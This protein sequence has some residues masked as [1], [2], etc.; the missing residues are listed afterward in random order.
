MTESEEANSSQAEIHLDWGPICRLKETI[1]PE[2]WQSPKGYVS[3]KTGALLVGHGVF[4]ELSI[5][6]VQLGCA[7]VS[8]ADLWNFQSCDL[9]NEG[10]FSFTCFDDGHR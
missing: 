8:I 3:A 7:G 5:H 6:A 10:H 1:K 4:S 2:P 9:L